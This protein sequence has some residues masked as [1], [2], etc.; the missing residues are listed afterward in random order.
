MKFI[1]LTAKKYPATTA[2]HI[3]IKEMA[4]AFAS[5]LADDF[6]LVVAND[7]SSELRDIPHKNLGLRIN[8]CV[9]LW[10]FVW[11]PLFIAKRHLNSKDTIF[12]SNDPNLLSIIIF[13]KR[14][15]NLK[16][17]I[18][19]EW[20]MLFGNWRD[21]F[22][23]KNSTRLIATTNHLKN[24]ISRKFNIDSEKILSV[25]GGVNL[26]KFNK[27]DKSIY[28]LRTGLGLPD[29]SFI[30]GYVGFY[31]T[32]GMGKGLDTMI[33]ALRLIE[34][35]NIIMAFVGGRG[36]EMQEYKAMAQEKG[37][38]DRII[39][40]PFVQTDDVPAY[41]RA[42]DILVVPY[43]DEPHFRDYGFPMKVYEYMASKKLIIYSDL[44]II[45]EVLN[46]CAGSFEP[47]NAKELSKKI[48]HYR[49]NSIDTENLAKKAYDKVVDCTWDERA[50][51]IIAFFK[52]HL[53]SNFA[54]S[55]ILFCFFILNK[56]D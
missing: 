34:D 35:K 7:R 42:M 49:N 52:R 48:I 51:N 31:K 1:Y 21:K 56:G 8:R 28:A 45:R 46:D 16:Y 36:Q 40:V 5:I 47:G 11:I 53:I 23:S 32:M 38:L 27:I 3:F 6:L 54:E 55:H 43:P 30:I 19:S 24:I 39:F 50:K 14:L 22:V 29:N 25:Y 26:G 37:V 13:W 20:H 18:V 41:E 44:P 10:Y 9:S 17:Q 4:T 33:D 12:F 2:D 15:L